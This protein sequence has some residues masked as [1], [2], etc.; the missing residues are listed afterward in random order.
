MLISAKAIAAYEKNGVVS[1]RNLKSSNYCL[2]K[3]YIK[4]KTKFD[5]LLLLDYNVCMLND[6]R[7][8]RSKEYTRL[9]LTY[10]YGKNIH[11]PD[12]NKNDRAIYNSLCNYCG[13]IEYYKSLG[14]KFT[15]ERKGKYIPVLDKLVDKNGYLYPPR[16]DQHHNMYMVLYY[17]AKKRNMT[18]VEYLQYLGYKIKDRKEWKVGKGRVCHRD[19]SGN[20]VER[21]V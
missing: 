20:I 17:S 6:L 11:I 3:L 2:Y 21:N 8:R 1:L 7:I 9:Y 15:Y 5:E 19:S 10:H 14:F 4:N 16:K 13:G 12:L 18:Y